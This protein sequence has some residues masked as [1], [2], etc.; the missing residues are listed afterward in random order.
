MGEIRIRRVRISTVVV[1]GALFVMVIAIGPVLASALL[2]TL[3]GQAAGCLPPA[4][5]PAAASVGSGEVRVAHANI[6]V[7]LPAGQFASDLARVTATGA[8]LVS[9]NETG[10]RSILQLRT[11]GY[12]AY[13][14]S[15]VTGQGRSTA[16]LWRTDRWARTDAGRRLL[17]DHGPQ[18]WDAGRSATWVTLRGSGDNTAA[19]VVSM[20]S[21]HHMINPAK[22]G[23]D[24]SLRRALYRR[25]M[26]RLADL[27]QTLS[28]RGPVF[29]GGDFN[30]QW[31][32]NDSWGPRRMLGRGGLSGASAMTS[33]MDV[34]G[35]RSTHDGGGTI[36]YLFFQAAA[37]APSR[38]RV[39]DLRSDHDLL[40]AD[41]ELRATPQGGGGAELATAGA[42]SPSTPTAGGPE[43]SRTSAVLGLSAAQWQHAGEVVSTGQSLGMGPQGIVV[44]LAV[45]SQESGFRVYANDGLGG[46]LAADQQGIGR[47]IRLPHDAVGTDHGSLGLF[48]QQWPWWGS[49]SELMDPG[50]SARKFYEA[51]A[52]IDSWQMLPVTV[53]AQQVQRSAYPDAYADDEGIAR[54]IYARLAGTASMSVG[55]LDNE[56]AHCA[57]QLPVTGDGQP[58]AS[59]GPVVLPVP[60][61]FAMSDQR[62]WGGSG[63][64]W[65]SWHTGTDFSVPCGTPVLAAHRGTVQI[66]TTQSWAGTWLVKV[67]QGPRGLSTWYAH[68]Q[69]LSVQDGD[70]VA[71]GRQ[72]G[73]VG[74]DGNATGCH[75]HFEV[76][77]RN[78]SIY[79][80]DNVN[81]STWLAQHSG[82]RVR[83][84]P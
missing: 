33:T 6:K 38:Q 35:Q 41:F 44:A 15:S 3:A 49:M 12:D 36:D 56:D 20:V 14:D 31:G 84:S 76:H 60:A 18:R 1:I 73:E 8:D 45:V 19:G 55:S 24:M 57:V 53:A 4:G 29:L 51:L 25:G 23:P 40:T 59:G 71:A 26:D 46:D 70:R 54:E 68:M 34:L 83:S 21:V 32:A 69:K 30:S 27:V 39:V 42:L 79:G 64:N 22:Y 74:A 11:R 67:S 58:L 13:R 82:Q 75:L 65:S 43:A 50:A 47:S 28:R 7:S 81:P 9:L 16:V 5:A 78:G 80:R 10:S 66:D 77:T 62:N 48:Q 2:V 37:A 52:G 17:V 63:A 61:G 72:I